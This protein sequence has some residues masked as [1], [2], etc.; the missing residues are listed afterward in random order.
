MRT[1]CSLAMWCLVAVVAAGSAT[2]HGAESPASSAASMLY[3]GDG[4]Y[5]RGSLAECPTLNTICWQARGTARPF[6][7][8]A[9][10]IR[11]AYFDSTGERPAPNGEYCV[12]LS[13]GD[14]L[15]ASLTGITPEHVEVESAQFGR[16]R[17]AR[18]KFAA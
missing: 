14:V 2:A 4:D 16:V 15:F 9:D 18:P 12:E 8:D 17:I 7:F 11:A 6:E 10:A 3:L 13:D 5:F 1:F